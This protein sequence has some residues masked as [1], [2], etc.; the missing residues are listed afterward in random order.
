MLFARGYRS[1]SASKKLIPAPNSSRQTSLL[2]LSSSHPHHTSAVAH[3]CGTT[4]G[5]VSPWEIAQ[6]WRFIN[7]IALNGGCSLITR[8]KFPVGW[9]EASSAVLKLD[10]PRYISFVRPAG[11]LM[12]LHLHP[13]LLMINHPSNRFPHVFR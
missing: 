2:H 8:R 9:T 4:R 13:A 3:G 11:V 5:T 10:D 7:V 1:T 6:T 12:F